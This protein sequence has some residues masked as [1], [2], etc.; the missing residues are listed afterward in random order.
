MGYTIAKGNY[1]SFFWVYN[2]LNK[3]QCGLP[4]WPH[5]YPDDILN[6]SRQTS[7]PWVGFDPTI[8]AF[9]RAKIF[10][11][12]GRAATVTDFYFCSNV[13]RKHLH[14]KA[15]RTQESGNETRMEAINADGN[16]ISRNG[17]ETDELEEQKANILRRMESSILSRGKCVYPRQLSVFGS[18]YVTINNCID[19]L[20]A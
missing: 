19:G 5:K 11:T 6:S 1:Q 13:L 3:F 9:E 20:S 4:W 14:I 8:P 16:F 10:H 18:R 2:F 17:E 15:C 12:L 7:M